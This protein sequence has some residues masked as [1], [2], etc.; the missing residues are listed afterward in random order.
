MPSLER[1]S[2][3]ATV[4]VICSDIDR[5]LLSGHF[6]LRI[7]VTAGRVSDLFARPRSYYPAPASRPGATRDDRGPAAGTRTR[8]APPTTGPRR[9][10]RPA[11][12]AAE[13][14]V[15]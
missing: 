11:R 1:V 4:G 12:P 2:G 14:R 8:R 3:G 6:P 7:S 10:A 13:A 5:R 9:R 15:G